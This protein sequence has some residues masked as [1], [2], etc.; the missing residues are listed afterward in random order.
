MHVQPAAG[1]S[2]PDDAEPL[3]RHTMLRDFTSPRRPG[4][5]PV[6]DAVFDRLPL[7]DALTRDVN[8]AWVRIIMVGWAV[9]C[10]GPIPWLVLKLDSG[11]FPSPSDGSV[12]NQHLAA[13]R[14][15]A[16][17]RLLRIGDLRATVDACDDVLDQFPASPAARD[18]LRTARERIEAE[19]TSAETQQ[20]VAELIEQGRG[21]YRKGQYRAASELFEQALEL[22][23]E[24]ELAASFL[25]LANE[26]QRGSSRRSPRTTAQRP[27]TA[28]A[29]TSR[30]S[31]PVAQ[32]TPGTA[33]ITVTFNSPLNAGVL[34]VTLND[35]VLAEIP[36]DFTTSGFMGFRRRS[37]GTVKRVLVAPSGQQR[38]GIQLRDPQRGLIGSAS[39]QRSLGAGSDWT[40]RVDLPA[41]KADASFYLVEKSR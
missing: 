2:F 41:A 6:R 31:E 34:T 29:V 8:P 1:S 3:P 33:R 38:I 18:L 30:V 17:D 20:R 26:R 19:R 27:S 39:F 22:D 10:L 35:T 5:Q 23:P 28:P 9:L 37:T 16:A 7:P 14:L 25:D 36:F 24:N 21:D 32:P 11:P 12:H 40:L 13:Q 15:M 4:Q